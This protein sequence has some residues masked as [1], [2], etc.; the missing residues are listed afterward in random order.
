MTLDRFVGHLPA[1]G[2]FLLLASFFSRSRRHRTL[3]SIR[4]MPSAIP[5]ALSS[6]RPCVN[7]RLP[8]EQTFLDA[9]ALK[10]R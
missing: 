3:G 7:L 6:I 8:C 5:R 1:T 9:R 2:T 4:D 10:T